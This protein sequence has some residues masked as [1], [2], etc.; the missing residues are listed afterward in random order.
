MTPTREINE[1]AWKEFC[2]RVEEDCRGALVTIELRQADGKTA[3]VARELP[4]RGLA[5]D[6]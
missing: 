4:L 1:S 6:D 3:T 2:H 5:M